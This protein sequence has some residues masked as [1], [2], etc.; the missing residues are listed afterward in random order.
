MMDID[1]AVSI[2]LALNIGDFEVHRALLMTDRK[3]V[4]RLCSCS[5]GAGGVSNGPRHLCASA[6]PHR[7]S[8]GDIPL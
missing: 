4:G 3:R 6:S 2:P 1:E 8:N 5:D 7:A